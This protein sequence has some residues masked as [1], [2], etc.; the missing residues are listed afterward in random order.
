MNDPLIAQGGLQYFSEHSQD[1][2]LPGGLPFD[3][4]AQ[5]VKVVGK[6][7]QIRTTLFYN[8]QAMVELP[9]VSVY[10]EAVV[11]ISGFHGSLDVALGHTNKDCK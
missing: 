2:K 1:D 7:V 6:E 8:G 10:E 11:A 5:N 9:L 4:I 3:R